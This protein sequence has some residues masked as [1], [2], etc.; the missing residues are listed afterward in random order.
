MVRLLIFVLS[1]SWWYVIGVV[2]RSGKAEGAPTREEIWANHWFRQQ[3]NSGYQLPSQNSRVGGRMADPNFR[4]PMLTAEARGMK[5]VLSAGEVRASM[6][7]TSAGMC[8]DF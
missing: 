1:C 2:N 8:L 5:V 4:K 6:S 3:Q 7:S